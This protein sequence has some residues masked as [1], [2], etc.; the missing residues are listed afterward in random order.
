M[1]A[2]PLSNWGWERCWLLGEHS[3]FWLI[4]FARYRIIF[5]AQDLEIYAGLFASA[6]LA[7]TILPAQSELGQ[8][9]TWFPVSQY[10]G[11]GGEPGAQ[12]PQ[13]NQKCQQPARWRAS[14]FQRFGVWVCCLA[15]CPVIGDPSPWQLACWGAVLALFNS[16]HTGK[17]RPLYRGSDTGLSCLVGTKEAGFAN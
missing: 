13:R 6:F 8:N 11:R 5:W 10:S 9:Q 12:I 1:L 14:R 15:G 2:Q 4:F 3:P 7:A 17:D 16:G